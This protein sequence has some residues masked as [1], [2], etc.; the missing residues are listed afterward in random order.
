MSIIELRK[1]AID[2]NKSL[3]STFEHIG[4]S[5][6][7]ITKYFCGKCAAPVLTYVE[8]WNK[9]YL[10]AGLLDDISILK[11]SKNIYYDESHFP[12]MEISEKNLKT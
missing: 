7:K 8:R 3:L 11:K 6:N 1:D 4:G 9:F 2:I 12:F 10:Y 5:G